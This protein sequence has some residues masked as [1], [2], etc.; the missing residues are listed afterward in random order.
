MRDKDPAGTCRRARGQCARKILLAGMLMVSLPLNR[1]ASGADQ[2]PPH[3]HTEAYVR[4]ARADEAY[5]RGRFADA[6]QHYQ[7]AVTAYRDLARA[8]PEWNPDIVEYRISF[9]RNRIE[10]CRARIEREK[11]ETASPAPSPASQP[12]SETTGQK[13]SPAAPQRTRHELKLW[14]S[15]YRSLQQENRYLRQR[16]EQAEESP[17]PA[18]SPAPDRPQQPVDPKPGE[19]EPLKQQLHQL[20]K[21]NTGLHQRLSNA[22][23]RVEQMA[24]LRQTNAPA[25]PPA[26]PPPV[27]DLM[28]RDLE[29][30]ELEK[31]LAAARQTNPDPPRKTADGMREQI[32]RLE[33]ENQALRDTIA[34]NANRLDRID[35]M[36]DM[37]RSLQ[38]QNRTLERTLRR[39]RK[40][41][42]P[43][44]DDEQ[45]VKLRP[46]ELPLST[47]TN[48]PAA[49]SPAPP[50]PL[51]QQ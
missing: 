18:A 26:S 13:P 6:L 16:L 21:A 51:L 4:L 48:T 10:T 45:N 44:A 3:P 27:G 47:R 29:I 7:Q 32:D 50:P 8:H 1:T 5:A 46:G 42:P 33:A 2:D 23:A 25:P 19:I 17:P 28:T 37:I 41:Q 30:A 15:R 24:A 49:D 35:R 20:R 39:F 38:K 40:Q 31:A 11:Q 36:E 34:F 22:L 14:Q 9:C 43:R 12:A